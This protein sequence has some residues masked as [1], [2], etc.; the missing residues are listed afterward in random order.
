MRDRMTK[1]CPAPR[2]RATGEME[3]PACG[4]RWEW[5]DGRPECNRKATPGKLGFVSRVNR[6]RDAK[7][8]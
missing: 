5:A 8:R 3:C 2:S 4:L 1:T 7:N 6:Y